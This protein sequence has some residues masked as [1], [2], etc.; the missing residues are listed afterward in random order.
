[1]D[2]Y[3]LSLET[4]TLNVVNVVI[5]QTFK[6]V[7]LDYHRDHKMSL[8]WRYQHVKFTFVMLIY[9]QIGRFMVCHWLF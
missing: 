2:N 6:S 5:L 1:V 3:K 9:I 7:I 4:G 8:I